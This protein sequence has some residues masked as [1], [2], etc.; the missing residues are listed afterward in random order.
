[1]AQPTP[2]CCNLGVHTTLLTVP[3]AKKQAVVD[4]HMLPSNTEPAKSWNL[5]MGTGHFVLLLDE[6]LINSHRKA[7]EEKLG[8]L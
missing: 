3:S 7:A 1:M 8:D 6:R 4:T 5:E 2:G